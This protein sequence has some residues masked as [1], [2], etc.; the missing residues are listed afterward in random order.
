ML[1]SEPAGIQN[2]GNGFCTGLGSPVLAQPAGVSVRIPNSLDSPNALE[3]SLGAR[4][5]LG[6]RAAIRADYVFRNFRDFYSARVDASTGS[7]TDTFGNRS[8][9]QIY[10]NTNNL[11]RRY[12]GVTVSGTYRVSGRTDVRSFSSIR[13]MAFS[14]AVGLGFLRRPRRLPTPPGRRGRRT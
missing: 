8:D 9:L 14:F 10:E 2:G 6:S 4:R 7:V 1:S 3:Y 5:Q 12:Q 13:F 11:K